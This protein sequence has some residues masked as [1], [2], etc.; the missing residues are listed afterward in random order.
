[1]FCMYKWAISISAYDLSI[2]EGD[3]QVGTINGK[4]VMQDSYFSISGGSDMDLF[5]IG[6]TNGILYFK[7]TPDYDYPNDVDQDNIYV[8][9]VKMQIASFVELAEVR[10]TVMRGKSLFLYTCA[11]I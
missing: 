10:V 9:L 7:V 8:V 1:M 11:F 6:S 5:N 3:T 4:V 2:V